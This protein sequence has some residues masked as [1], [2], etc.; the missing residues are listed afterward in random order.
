MAELSAAGFESASVRPFGVKKYEA[1]GVCEWH[2]TIEPALLKKLLGAQN[3]EARAYAAGTLARVFGLSSSFW[4]VMALG[5]IIF[6]LGV[7][8]TGKRRAPA[9]SDAVQPATRKESTATI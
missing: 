8:L 6:Y 4:L 3:P 1:L 2:E 7:L 5:W 9:P